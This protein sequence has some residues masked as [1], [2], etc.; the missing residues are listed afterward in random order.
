MPFG[1]GR[2][3]WREEDKLQNM[4]LNL[5]PICFLLVT[6]IPL[7]QYTFIQNLTVLQA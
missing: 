5:F 2:M 6:S 4:H 1:M 7:L 3:Q